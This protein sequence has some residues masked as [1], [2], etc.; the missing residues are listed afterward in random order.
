VYYV[1]VVIF[2]TGSGDGFPC[3][4]ALSQALSGDPVGVQ[5]AVDW[6]E[7][8]PQTRNGGC[9]RVVRSGSISVDPKSRS[10]QGTYSIPPIAA[11]RVYESLDTAL[12][13]AEDVLVAR[14]NPGLLLAD[15]R[16]DVQAELAS[17]DDAITAK[18]Q[19]VNLCPRGRSEDVDSLFKRFV[20]VEFNR[21]DIVWTQGSASD[22]A[23][24]LV[25]GTLIAT[26]DDTD[27]S[28]VVREGSMLG[29]LGLV[30]GLNRLS[31]VKCPSDRAVCFRLD[32]KDW[33]VLTSQQPKVARLIDDIVIRYLT[34][35]VQHVSNRIFETRC[36]PI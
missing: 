8:V 29:E 22:C 20:R 18:R 13:F 14:V 23:L 34:H 30:H 25:V 6:S 26:V 9:R 5:N 2:V 32:S 28:E 1:E 16:T 7:M 19:L 12:M 15:T 21:N 36:L 10:I 27:A 31:T 4:Y 3:E 35:R 24:L 33:D 11:N 17:Q